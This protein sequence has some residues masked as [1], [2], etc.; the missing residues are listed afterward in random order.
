MPQPRVR[1][2][3]EVR[4]QQGGGRERGRITLQP[5]SREPRNVQ[6]TYERKHIYISR[7]A[8]SKKHS[9]LLVPARESK[10]LGR[11]PRCE[12][13]H[14]RSILL[15]VSAALRL[16]VNLARARRR[17][18]RSHA[19]V[20][21]SRNRDHEVAKLVVKRQS[22]RKTAASSRRRTCLSVPCALESAVPHAHSGCGL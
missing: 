10:S 3:R 19:R 22:I 6:M 11:A 18:A 8:E 20:R 14:D 16:P 5:C 9:R 13:S 7:P 1:P 17:P 12:A 15:E 21:C 2:R 4:G